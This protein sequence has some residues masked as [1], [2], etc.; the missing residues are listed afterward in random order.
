MSATFDTPTDPLLEWLYHV[1][2]VGLVIGPNIIREENLV[3]PRQT[4]VD[5]AAV[6]QFLDDEDGPALRDA[7]AF[8]ANVLGWEARYVAGAPG[9]PELPQRSRRARSRARRDVDA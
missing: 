2:P 6:E 7:W 4:A 5:N 8:F 9:G 1:G 3:A